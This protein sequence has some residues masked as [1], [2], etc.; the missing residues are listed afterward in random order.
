M[1]VCSVD[2]LTVLLEAS[3]LIILHGIS[4][5]AV[6]VLSHNQHKPLTFILGHVVIFL[7]LN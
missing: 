4:V 7:L 2:F 1:W 6:G 5:V 3:C